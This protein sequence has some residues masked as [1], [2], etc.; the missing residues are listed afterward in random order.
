MHG[1]LVTLFVVA[2]P[3]GNLNDITLRAIDVLRQVRLIAAEDTRVTRRLLGRY[4]ISTPLTSYREQNS[5]A[6]LPVLIEAL[7]KQDVALVSDAGM[8]GINDPGAVLVAAAASAGVAIESIPGP[9][10]VTAALGVS[11]F[12]INGF[13]YLGFLPRRRSDRDKLLKSMVYEP[14]AIVAF[15]AP[16]RLRASL[17]DIARALGDRNIAVCHELTKLHEEVYRGTATQ[18]LDHFKDPKGEFTLVIEG[19]VHPRMMIEDETSRTLMW[20][21]RTHGIRAK[22][23]VAIVT[24]QTGITK[25]NAYRLWLEMGEPATSRERET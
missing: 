13:L 20:S 15:E 21:L 2:T 1:I 6:K 23:A 17:E 25:H 9:S 3:I 18:A 11:G 10:A 22:S 19:N 8:P 7:G 5:S 16:H 12:R 14:L 24:E 4:G